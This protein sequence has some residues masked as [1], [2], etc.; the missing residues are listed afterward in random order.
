MTC[1]VDWVRTKQVTVVHFTF[2]RDI[3]AAARKARETRKRYMEWLQQRVQELEE[4]NR[5]FLAQLT[6]LSERW[7]ATQ[8]TPAQCMFSSIHFTTN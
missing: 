4:E 1:V 8:A 6:E 2:C 7:V 3:R 5:Y